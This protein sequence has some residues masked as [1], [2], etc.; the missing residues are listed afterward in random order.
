MNSIKKWYTKK[1]NKYKKRFSEISFKLYIKT[2]IL[3]ITYVLINLINSMLLRIVTMGNLFSFKAIIADLVFIA[4]VGSLAY[5]LKPKK[6][7]KVLFP[8]TILMTVVCIVNAIYY[9]NYVSF[10]SFSLLSTA[11]FLGD[12]DGAVVTSLIHLKDVVLIFPPF[13]L[14]FVHY[15]LKRKKYYEGVE[16]IERGKKRLLNTLMIGIVLLLLTIALMVPSDYSRLKKQWNRE[17][18][19]NRFGIYVYQLNDLVRSLQPKFNNLFGYDKAFKTFRE[20]YSKKQEEEKVVTNEYTN[21]FEG[22]NVIVIHAESIMQENM[23]LS[24]NGKELTPNLNKIASEGLYFNN[25]YSQVSVG[26]SSDT[27]F[28]LNTSLLPVSSGTVFVNYWNRKYEAIPS[29]L[30]QK[31]YYT[32]SMHA[33]NGSFWN[34]NVMHKTLGYDKFYSKDSYEIDEI[35]GLG[36]SDKSFFKQSISKLEKIKEKNGKFYVTL[37][38]L[39]NHTP[40]DDTKLFSDYTVD[41]KYNTTDEN[42]NTIEQTLPYLEGTKLGNYYKSTHYAD[43]ALGEFF[44]ELDSAGLLEDTVVVIYGDHDAKL[45]KKEYDYFYN[46]DFETGE[47]L[48]EDDP[49]YKEVDYYTYELNRKVPFIIWTKDSKNNPLLNKTVDKVMGMYDVMP[50][51]ANMFNFDSTYALGHDIFSVDENIV[52]FPNGN[53][54]TNKMYYNDQKDEYL[55]L[56]NSVVN[57]GEI[58]K[59]KEYA[60]KLLDVSDSLIIYDLLNEDREENSNE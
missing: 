45:A 31:G 18:L 33:N 11:S 57:D 53:W 47:K 52:V 27:E 48:D 12:M 14:I 46:Y 16:K 3:F 49:N 5:L 19:V 22:K 40:F 32:A 20:F 50:T 28:T 25:F 4:F 58:E 13:V 44:N 6:Q 17:Y 42:G 59:N 39:S 1:I 7:I 23:T 29:L 2:N 30:K 15:S 24:F 51:L 41:Y 9:E 8:L 21:I 34:R 35:V 38:M 60:N 55:L 54:L 26:T 37:I 36:L 56:Q 43:E 10:A